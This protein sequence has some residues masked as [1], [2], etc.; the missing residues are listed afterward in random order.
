MST[1][2]S[3]RAIASNPNRTKRISGGTVFFLIQ[4]SREFLH[5]VSGVSVVSL[6]EGQIFTSG[7]TGAPLSR[8]MV[9]KS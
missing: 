6:G 1:L 2:R 9:R 5:I 8:S 4:G 7:H 3:V